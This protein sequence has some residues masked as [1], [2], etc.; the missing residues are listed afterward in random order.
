MLHAALSGNHQLFARQ[1]SIEETWRVVQPLLDHPP[2]VQLYPRGSWGLPW[3]AV[4]LWPSPVAAAVA[5]QD[6]KKDRR[7]IWNSVVAIRPFK[8][9]PPIRVKSWIANPTQPAGSTLVFLNLQVV[10]SDV[11]RR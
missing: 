11:R 8:G 1:D 2:D 7:E 5:A 9:L 10:M 3:R 6:F 4:L